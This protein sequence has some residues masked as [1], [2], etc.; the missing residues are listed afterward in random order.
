MLH[1]ND[2][3]VRSQE[4]ADCSGGAETL[5]NIEVGGRLVEH[6]AENILVTK[7]KAVFAKAY[8]SACCTQTIAI[9]NR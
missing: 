8:T 4:I 6:I 1:D 9:A 2:I 5:L 3:V 7:K